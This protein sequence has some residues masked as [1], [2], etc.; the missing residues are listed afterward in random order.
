MFEW[1]VDFSGEVILCDVT[2]EYPLLLLD[3]S[4]ETLVVVDA[5]VTVEVGVERPS[6]VDS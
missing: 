2:T 4:S 6:V 1:V 5:W 3:I